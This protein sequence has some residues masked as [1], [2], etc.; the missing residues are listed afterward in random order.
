MIFPEDKFW[1]P[2]TIL[3]L[4][5]PEEMALCKMAQ[6][7]FFQDI[8]NWAPRNDICPKCKIN[9]FQNV[10]WLWNPK[11]PWKSKRI[12]QDGIL[13]LRVSGITLKEANSKPITYCP[14]CKHSFL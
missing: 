5:T 1:Q 3:K 14:H 8:T 13:V 12:T 9:I 7:K 6:Q 2:K 4:K 10:G 11:I